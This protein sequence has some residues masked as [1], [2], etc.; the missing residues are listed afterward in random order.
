MKKEEKS[1]TLSPA[2]FYYLWNYLEWGGAQ[3]LFFGLMKEAKK[4]GEVSALMPTGSHQQLLKFL[5]NLEVPYKF[6]DAHADTKPAPTL[7]RKIQRH[8]N[9]LKSEFVLIT[10][11]KKFN[12]KDSIIHT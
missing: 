5:D 6:F 4:Y 10:Y 7:K 12:F 9:K 11:L 3:V 1:K 8:W 2:K